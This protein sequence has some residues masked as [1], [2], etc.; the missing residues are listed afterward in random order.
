ML[1]AEPYQFSSMKD[2]RSVRADH[3]KIGCAVT[4]KYAVAARRNAMEARS[5]AGGGSKMSW[6]LFYPQYV[7]QRLVWSCNMRYNRPKRMMKADQ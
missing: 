1:I 2:E 4:G 7:Q 3:G 5:L 6:N